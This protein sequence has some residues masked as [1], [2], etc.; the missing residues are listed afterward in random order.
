MFFIHILLSLYIY[1]EYYILH[2][3]QTYWCVINTLFR[4][5][6]TKGSR[7]KETT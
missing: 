7:N 1:I 4:Q 5:M 2:V 6:K 3:L